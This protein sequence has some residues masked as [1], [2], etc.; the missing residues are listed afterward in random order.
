MKASASNEQILQIWLPHSTTSV[1]IALFFIYPTS[2]FVMKNLWKRDASYQIIMFILK[3]LQSSTI[4]IKF[5]PVE[6]I[7]SQGSF[8]LSQWPVASTFTLGYD[9]K[10][11]I[12]PIS[13]DDAIF[14]FRSRLFLYTG[15]IFKFA[16]TKQS[17]ARSVDLSGPGATAVF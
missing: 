3:Q 16:Y 6:L 14:S 15:Y 12:Y 2:I 7:Q 13:T 10:K 11:A 17:G 5:Y 4:Q 9:R 8:N 1:M